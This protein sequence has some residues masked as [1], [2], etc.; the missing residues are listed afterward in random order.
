MTRLRSAVRAVA[1]Q[2]P[3]AWDSATTV[4]GGRFLGALVL[5]LIAALMAGG[6]L[7]FLTANGVI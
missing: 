4:V 5:A 1:E 7:L 2:L 3:A 6:W